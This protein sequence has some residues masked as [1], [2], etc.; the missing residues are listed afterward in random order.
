VRDIDDEFLL[1]PDLLVAPVFEPGCTARQVYLPKGTWYGWHTAEVTEGGTF[2]VVPTPMRTIPIF[3]RGGSV[4]PMWPDAPPST[5]RYHPLVIE[6]HLFVPGVDGTHTS[7]LQE[8]DGLTFAALQGACYR[9]TLEVTR[10]GDRLT[11]RGDAAGDGY[12]GFKR[13]EFHLVIHGAAPDTVEV[14]GT[15]V[16]LAG[17]RVTLPNRGTSF[18]IALDL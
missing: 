11:L 14:D 3:A 2:L 4:I 18:S 15:Q 17:G 1:G 5:A 9:T 13:E 8:D 10:A 16:P 12:E 7:L 6:L